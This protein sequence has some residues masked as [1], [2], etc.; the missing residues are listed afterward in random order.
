MSVA[1]NF[2]YVLPSFRYLSDVDY[3]PLLGFLGLRPRFVEDT[4]QQ[5]YGDRAQM[6]QEPWMNFSG[7]AAVVGL[8]LRSAALTSSV[9]MPSH[10]SG[11]ITSPLIQLLSAFFIPLSCFSNLRLLTSR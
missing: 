4:R 1:L 8:I 7:P 6:V 9:E 11:T 3:S 10:T 5:E 2:L